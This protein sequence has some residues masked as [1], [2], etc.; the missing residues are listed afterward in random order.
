MATPLPQGDR[1]FTE[2]LTPRLRLARLRHDDIGALLT[3][4]N[5]P[6][7][8]VF[9]DWSLPFTRMDASLLVGASSTPLV[10]GTWF[11]YGIFD[12]TDGQLL[13]DI[14]LLRDGQQPDTLTVGYTLDRRWWG[15][16]IAGEAVGAVLDHATA[17]VDAA[18]VTADALASNAASLRLL[19]RLG[20]VE[21]ERTAR[22]E[23]IDGVWHDEV[24]M[25][26]GRARVGRVVGAVLVGGRSSRM[27]SPKPLVDVAGSSMFEWVTGAML[28]AGLEVVVVGA[29]ATP[30]HPFHTLADPSGIR[31]PAA[32]IAAA[33]RHAG[34]APVFV[35]A[36][37][38]P[39]LSPPTI[40]R[41][42][43]IDGDIVAPHDERAQVTCAVYRPEAMP[44]IDALTGVDPAPSLQQIVNANGVLVDAGTWRGWGEDGRSWRSLDTPASIDR[45][46]KELGSPL[47]PW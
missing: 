9:Q 44:A 14:G 6:D 41:L 31:G 17:L 45:G 40:R 1:W 21:V 4:R 35:T 42:L 43:A 37:D 15:Q 29:G 24:R 26:L 34:G 33:I 3:Y 30:D 36:A 19:E 13:G 28:A 8:A 16:G 18:A 7:V 22:S 32:G 12:R 46:T 20:F 38:Q 23:R 2:L 27:G 11:Q 39:W 47:T 5:D 25:R 10:P